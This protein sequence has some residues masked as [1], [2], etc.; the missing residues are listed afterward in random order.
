MKNYN[1]GGCRKIILEQ[2]AKLVPSYINRCVVRCDIKPSA[3]SGAH[4]VKIS[5]SNDGYSVNFNTYNVYSE[6]RT[7]FNAGFG[8]W[9][10]VSLNGHFLGKF[11]DT[12]KF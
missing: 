8:E 4:I 6:V 2:V 10:S 11:Q 12:A 5:V 3:P 1:A 7:V 9:F